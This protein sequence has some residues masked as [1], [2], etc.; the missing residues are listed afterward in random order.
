[1]LTVL[2]ITGPIFLIIAFGFIAVRSGLMSQG[3]SKGLGIYVLNFALPALLFKALAQ[4]PLRQS[5]NIELL[6]IYSAGSLL[7]L[8]LAIG[9]GILVQKRGLQNATLLA[10]GMTLSNSAFMGF[11]IAERL[12][13]PAATGT[14]AVY[15]TVENL[16]MLPVV[17]VIA[18]LGRK[19]GSHWARLVQGIVLR[20][21]KNPLILSI[22]LGV[23]FS[24]LELQVP[25]MMGRAIELLAGSSAPVAL[26]YI[27]GTLAT[28]RWTGMRGDIAGVVIGKLLVHP[29]SVFSVF[30]FFPL[31]DPAL[32][33][34]AIINASMPMATIYALLG[35]K[36]G[37]EG[38]CSAALVVTTVI[39]FFTITCLLWMIGVG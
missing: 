7:A 13:G 22:L 32:R 36:Y 28:I 29:L 35:Q 39:S 26:F 8:S 17:L 9:Y 30:L 5:L 15:V 4:H 18:E 38:F 12:I 25:T 31:T 6:T 33:Q 37:Q 27:G 21:S 11:P 19:R 2:G 1:M 10:M 24:L 23:L 34:A 14:L 16:I 20:L 3:E